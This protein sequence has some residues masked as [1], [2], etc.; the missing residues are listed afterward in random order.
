MFQDYTKIEWPNLDNIYKTNNFINNF[1]KNIKNYKLNYTWYEFTCII[2]ILV[3]MNFS[4]II[5]D[6]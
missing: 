2:D 4:P 3:H 1:L 6:M 5:D